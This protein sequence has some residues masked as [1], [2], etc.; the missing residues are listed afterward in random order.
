MIKLI[1]QLFK[2]RSHAMGDF[3][4]FHRYASPKEKENLLREVVRQANKD[5]KDLMETY[6]RSQ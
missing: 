4:S 6:A 2:R 3:S 5:Q 1:K